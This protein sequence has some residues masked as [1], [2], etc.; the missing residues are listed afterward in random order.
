MAKKINVKFLHPTDG[1][2]MEVEIEDNL[3]APAAINEL[4]ACNFIPDNPSGGYLLHVKGGNEIRGNQTFAE[5]GVTE[6]ST[7]RVVPVTDA[8]SFERQERGE[9]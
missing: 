4:I 5:C 1:T 7:I 8:G 6:G 9:I 3:T 2:D